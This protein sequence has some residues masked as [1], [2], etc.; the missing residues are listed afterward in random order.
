MGYAG[1]QNIYEGTIRRMVMQALEEQEEAFRKLHGSD[2][3]EQLM[4]YLRQCAMELNHAPWPGEVPGGDL[5]RERFGSWEN[6]LA[7]AKL[8]RLRGER[9]P[10]T[11]LRVK[12]EEKRQREIYRQKKNEKKLLAQKRRSQQTSRKKKENSNS[13]SL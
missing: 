3:N 5:I 10:E 9:K 4:D 6:G 13:G 7:A 8:H 11:F 12:Q 1:R 2:T